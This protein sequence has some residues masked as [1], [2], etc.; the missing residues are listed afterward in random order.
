MVMTELLSALFG[1]ALA[2]VIVSYNN[3]PDDDDD[4]LDGG[5]MTPVYNP[6]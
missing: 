3:Q 1:L 4:H 2:W 6:I 5:M